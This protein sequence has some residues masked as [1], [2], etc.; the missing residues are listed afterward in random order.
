MTNIEFLYYF[1]IYFFMKTHV[2]LNSPY[3]IFSNY[4]FVM[5]C[6]TALDAKRVSKKVSMDFTTMNSAYLFRGRFMFSD[7][8]QQF[9][10]KMVFDIKFK[11]P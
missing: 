11:V 9:C 5:H 6:R 7:N 2:F 1:I 10:K 8:R 4:P 3:H